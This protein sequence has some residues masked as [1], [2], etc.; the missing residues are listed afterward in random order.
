[1]LFFCPA[2]HW[3]K[4]CA[5]LTLIDVC[6]VRIMNFTPNRRRIAIYGDRFMPKKPFS[7]A[8]RGQL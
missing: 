3:H 5:A 1:M 8:M 6:S 7:P 2:F 4:P